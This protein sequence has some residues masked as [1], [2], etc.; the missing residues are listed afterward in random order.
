MLACVSLCAA[1]LSAQQVRVVAPLGALAPR[2]VEQSDDDPGDRVEM[3]EN[4]NLDRYLERAQSFLDRDD[5]TAAVE[6]LQDVIEGKTV[7]VFATRPDEVDPAAAAAAAGTDPDSSQP[8]GTT[9]P[10]TTSPGTTSLGTTSPGT[11]SLA[12]TGVINFRPVGG[13]TSQ[14]SG[15][16]AGGSELDARNAVF[17]RDGRIYRPVRRLCHELLARMPDVGIQIYRTTYEFAAEQMLA[18]AVASGSATALEQV[19]N[20]YFIT[21]PAGRAMMMLA[22]RLMHEGRYRA[23]VQVLLDLLEVYPAQNR[24]LLGIRRRA[25]RDQV[26]ARSLWGSGVCSG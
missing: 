13:N 19:A 18:E 14:H 4:P 9:S 25:L 12:A 26:A 2:A 15:D 24:K 23:C 1:V 21:L 3:F 8:A 16:P 10:G 6:V 20:R 7:E 11:T 17:S 5:Y 22:D